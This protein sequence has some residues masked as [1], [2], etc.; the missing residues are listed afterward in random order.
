MKAWH[1]AVALENLL[2]DTFYVWQEVVIIGS[3]AFACE[4]MEA[5]SRNG[6]RHITLISRPRTR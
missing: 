6:A 1:N 5:A 2:K 3:G 4:A